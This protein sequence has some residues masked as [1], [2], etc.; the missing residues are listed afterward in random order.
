V[1]TGSIAARVSPRAQSH[2]FGLSPVRLSRS[3][4]EGVGLS[5]VILCGRTKF[6]LS[7][8]KLNIRNKNYVQMTVWPH[9]LLLFRLDT[10]RFMDEENWEEVL[11]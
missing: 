4:A 10:L 11:Q 6:L 7:L 3:P 2:L 8:A 5:E 1:D 9:L